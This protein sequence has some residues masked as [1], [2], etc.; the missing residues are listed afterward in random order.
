MNREVIFIDANVL[1]E[2]ILKGRKNIIKAQDYVSSHDIIISP[3][4]A[5]LFV[6]FG[7]RDGLEL[8]L[9]LDMLIKHRF[10]NFGIEEVM[11]AT[12]NYQDDDFEDAL[13][14]ACAVMQDCQTFV[15]FDKK[16]AQEYSQFID[17]KVL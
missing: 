16:L 4:S 7:L 10:T 8:N 13:Q 6:Y 5:H 17:V 12:K 2:T 14:V 3:L 1:L 15:T 9:L 11:W